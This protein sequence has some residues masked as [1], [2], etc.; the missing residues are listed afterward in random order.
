MVNECAGGFLGPQLGPKESRVGS[1]A[2]HLC[3]AVGKAT[4]IV[5]WLICLRTSFWRWRRP[6]CCP[7]VCLLSSALFCGILSQ[8]HPSQQGF[9]VTRFGLETSHPTHTNHNFIRK[10][11]AD[12]RKKIPLS[13]HQLPMSCARG[14][15]I[16]LP[17][18]LARSKSPSKCTNCRSAVAPRTAQ[19]RPATASSHLRR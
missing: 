4:V 14:P 3:C 19:C 9:L 2:I 5:T 15:K 10:P 16:T 11:C 8:Q 12:K 17:A 7:R 1:R 18:P 13:E 6:A